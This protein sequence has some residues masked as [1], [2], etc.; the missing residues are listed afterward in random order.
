MIRPAR[1]SEAAQIHRLIAANLGAG[2]PRHS[3]WLKERLASDTGIVLIDHD[4]AG[5]VG[6]IVG[7]VVTDEAEI[8]D[9]VIHEHSR[10]TGR[11]QQLVS[12]FE[13]LAE[14]MGAKKVF[15]E[16][17]TDNR[18]AITLYTK[19]GYIRSGCRPGY[20]A[21]GQDALLMCK[22]LNTKP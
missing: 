12:E 21:D 14:S 10:R 15:L 6:A 16:V 19:R 17:R 13:R 8:H 5:V 7:H 4:D 2:T 9:I 18:P 20:Y 22:D 3:T 1:Q 11:G